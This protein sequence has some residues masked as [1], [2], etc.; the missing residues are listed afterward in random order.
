MSSIDSKNEPTDLKI[1]PTDLKTDE[2]EDLYMD[3]SKPHISR[4]QIQKIIG[5]KPQNLEIYRR[6]LVH[7]S[8]QKNVKYMQ[9]INEPVQDYMLQSFERLEYLGDAVLNLV[10][11]EVVYDK[12]PDSDEGFLTR[13]RTK[14]V[15]GSN[16]AKLARVLDLGSYIL[17]GSGT[18]RIK[19]AENIVI[20]D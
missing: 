8:L 9:S 6:A 10:T 11:A 12:Y 19:N 3:L 4:E 18:V 14:I 2:E 16:C 15:R 5:F 13:I 1:E 7:K 17:T 20:N